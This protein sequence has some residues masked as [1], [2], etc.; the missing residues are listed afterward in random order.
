[1]REKF[2][3]LIKTCITG[4]DSYRDCKKHGTAIRQLAEQQLI[5]PPDR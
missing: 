1:M 5:K 2:N 3:Q 4:P